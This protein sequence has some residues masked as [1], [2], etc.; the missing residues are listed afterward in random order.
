MLFFI[1]QKFKSKQ[2]KNMSYVALTGNGKPRCQA[3]YASGKKAGTQCINESFL[4]SMCKAHQTQ[5]AEFKAK[6]QEAGK[7]DDDN[8]SYPVCKGM[9]FQGKNA[10]KQ[11]D[12]AGKY[13]GFCHRHVRQNK[14]KSKQTI[15]GEQWDEGKNIL[16][17]VLNADAKNLDN[18]KKKIQTFLGQFPDS[19][20]DT[21]GEADVKVEPNVKVE[22]DAKA[23][24]VNPFNVKSKKNDDDDDDDDDKEE[25]KKKSQ[26]KKT[27]GA[28]KNKKNN[29]K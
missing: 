23:D 13:D 2:K 17:E 18:L 16:C 12:Q 19:D 8:S 4:N 9:R 1:L 29:K 11:C 22:A 3:T 21:D 28:D 27:E 26:K 24:A 7:N 20:T 15:S 5:T 6:A 14:N 10:G 25:T